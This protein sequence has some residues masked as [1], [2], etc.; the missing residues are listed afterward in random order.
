MSRTLSATA[1]AALFAQQT[2][3]A[4]LTLLEIDHPD[5]DAPI[6]V[7]NNTENIVS[8]GVTFCACAFDV[9]P[10]DDLSEAPPSVTLSI[11]NVDRSI[12]YALESI[13]SPPTIKMWVIVGSTPNVEEIGPIEFSLLAVS[14]D[15]LTIECTLGF[16]PILN[17]S[18]PGHSFTPDL[19]PGIF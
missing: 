19:F 3:Q 4:L 12:T 17:E 6:R 14:Y 18:I 15:V 8:G 2:G 11:C 13:A 16:E 9:P 1:R 5:L 10:P 7:V